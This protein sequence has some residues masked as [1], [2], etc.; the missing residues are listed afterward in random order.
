[1]AMKRTKPFSESVKA[2]CAG[3]RPDDPGFVTNLDI[4]A[5]WGLKSWSS[6]LSFN[7]S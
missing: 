2:I 7:Y 3:V 1:M 5:V 6:I 4:K